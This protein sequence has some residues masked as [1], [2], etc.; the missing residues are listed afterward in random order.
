VYDRAIDVK[1][2]RLRKT[3]EVDPSNPK[4]IL[5]ERRAGYLFNAVVEVV[6]QVGKGHF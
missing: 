2:L 3:I 6:V 4:F 5:T 1:I